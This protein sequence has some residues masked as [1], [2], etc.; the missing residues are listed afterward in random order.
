MLKKISLIALLMFTVAL[1]TNAETKEELSAKMYIT[2]LEH[3]DRY[4]SPLAAIL[5]WF[6][7]EKGNHAHEVMGE[8]LEGLTATVGDYSVEF[9]FIELGLEAI[10]LALNRIQQIPVAGKD[11]IPFANRASAFIKSILVGYSKM[12]G[13]T[14]YYKELFD[15][16]NL[17]YSM[18]EE[19]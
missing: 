6:S 7:D 14:D 12:Y 17:T 8:Y 1:D 16:V 19:E 15:A 9:A 13:D 3:T 2:S 18:V 10:D 4:D 11:L 5:D